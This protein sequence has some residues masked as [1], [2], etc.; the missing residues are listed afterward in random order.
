MIQFLSDNIDQLDLALDQL[1]VCDRNFDRFALMLVD[2]VVELTLHRFIQDKAYENEMWRRFSEPKHDQKL[3][4]KG[5]GQNF[6]NKARA[7]R[8]LGLFGESLCESI[9]NLHTY[10][11]SSYHKGLRHEGIL[12]SL[13]M[14]YFKCTCEVLKA[15]EPQM[16]CWSSQ[17][18]ISYRAKKYLGDT[19]IMNHKEAFHLAYVRLGE[20]VSSME[21]TLIHDLTEDM[22]S[23]IDSIDDAINFLSTDGPVDKNRDEVVVDSQALPF[24]FTDE[25]KR[26]ALERGYSNQTLGGL[27]HWLLANYNW[28][29]PADPIA[30]WQ[31]RLKSLYSEKDEH[32]A[33]KKYCDFMRQTDDIRS[34]IEESAMQLDGHIQQQIGIMRGN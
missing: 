2:N 15:Y 12:H 29:V 6:D 16:W 33:L 19:G 4:Q 34:K 25:G 10:R 31:S 22:R 14:F 21:N 17:D 30:S 11:N 8:K 7:A 3:I 20:V 27:I 5:L 26:F 23:T 28:P 9:L 32:K 13:A 24:V 18:K 1:A